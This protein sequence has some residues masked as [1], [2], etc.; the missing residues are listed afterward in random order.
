[1]TIFAILM[2]QP[3]PALAEEIKR[4]YPNDHYV[5]NE[6]QWLVSSKQ[7]VVEVSRAIGVSA[8]PDAAKQ[9]LKGLAVIFATSS[10][11]GRAP[12]QLWDWVKVK[13]EGTPGG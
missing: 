11:F 5:L 2:P 6:T 13:L 4:L 3:Q 1:M 10:Y 7:T 12:T 8:D 9:P